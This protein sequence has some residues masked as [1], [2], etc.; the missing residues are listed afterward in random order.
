MKKYLI[1]EVIMALALLL[2]PMGVALAQETD[3][4]KVMEAYDLALNEKN[5]AGALDLFTDDAVLTT[6]QGQFVG[7]EQIRTWL[8]RLVAQNERIEVAG[9]QV[10]GGKVTWQNQFFRA[11]LPGLSNEPLD[12]QAE[13]VVEAGKIKT[14]SSM[15]TDESQAK[16]DAA[17][18]AQPVATPAQETAAAP[19]PEAAAPAQDTSTPA[20]LPG[21][22]GTFASTFLWIVGLIVL[23]GILLGAGLASKYLRRSV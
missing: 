22:G 19:A 18:A 17:L 2:A 11:D 3:P 13:A 6:R 23:G 1:I 15:L 21:T 8:E 16:L 9:R 14:F 7:K 5:V 10:D 12:A 4:L 20:Q